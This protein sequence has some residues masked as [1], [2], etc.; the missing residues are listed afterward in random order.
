MK[1]KSCKI[2]SEQAKL[3]VSEFFC[4]QKRAFLSSRDKSEIFSMKNSKFEG[5]FLT[6]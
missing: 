1:V 5:L 4:H 6:E 2:E 3:S